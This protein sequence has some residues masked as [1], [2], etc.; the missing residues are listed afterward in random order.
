M[1]EE[2]FSD[3]VEP[4]RQNRSEPRY[5]TDTMA[6]IPLHVI[7]EN[8]SSERRITPSW[9]ISQLRAKLEP[10]TGVPPSSQRITL[11]T[12]TGDKINIE[13][14]DE[15]NTRLS[16]FPLV[17]YAELQV[18]KVAA[19]LA[20]PAFTPLPGHIKDEGLGYSNHV[21]SIRV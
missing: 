7:S 16:R 6:D 20:H 5:V 13:A 14:A 10:I 12:S 8:S 18:G 3:P 9:T 19:G 15:E 11:E 1:E 21:L 4:E 2:P 17:A